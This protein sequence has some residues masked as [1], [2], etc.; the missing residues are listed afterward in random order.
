MAEEFNNEIHVGPPPPLRKRRSFG[1]LVWLLVLMIVAG[2]AAYGWV[3]YDRLAE[4]TRSAAAATGATADRSVAADDF[5]AF[6]QKTTTALQAA[7][8][9]LAAQ[10][11]ELKRLSDTVEGLTGQV[12]ALTAKPDQT[13]A[14]GTPPPAFASPRPPPATAAAARPTPTAPRKR[15]AAPTP[16]GAISVGGA[17]LPAQPAAR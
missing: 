5:E 4:L 7:T 2:G 1:W 11:A 9:Q 6:Q 10:Q 16:A 17:P 3:N 12:A 8:D 14:V 13:Q 15:P